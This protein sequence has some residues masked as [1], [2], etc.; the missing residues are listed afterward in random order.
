M[1]IFFHDHKVPRGTTTNSRAYCALTENHLK[2]A[3]MSQPLGIVGSGMML[4]HDNA[5]PYTSRVTS[6]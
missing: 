2:S 5:Q 1:L 6:Q 4:Q 3:F